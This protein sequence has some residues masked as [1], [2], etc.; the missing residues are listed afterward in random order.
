MGHE[1]LIWK[2]MR[3]SRRAGSFVTGALLFIC[4]Y[5]CMLYALQRSDRASLILGLTTGVIALR[6]IGFRL[7]GRE[8]GDGD[9]ISFDLPYKIIYITMIIGPLGLLLFVRYLYPSQINHRL[10]WILLIVASPYYTLVLISPV[11]VYT[12]YL[13]ILKYLSLAMVA[14][15][16]YYLWKGYRANEVGSYISLLGGL[17]FGISCVMDV[18]KASGWTWLPSNSLSFG[19]LVFIIAQSQ[20]VALQF[21]QAFRRAQYLTVSLRDEVEHQTRDTACILD[22]IRQGVY[23]VD[24]ENLAIGAVRSPYLNQI[25][26]HARDSQTLDDLLI[27]PMQVSNDRKSQLTSTIQAAIGSDLFNFEVNAKCLVEEADFKLEHG[28]SRHLVLDWAPMVDD[29]DQVDKILVCLRDLTEERQL[30]SQTRHHREQ[31][32]MIEELANITEVR[33]RRF[34]QRTRALIE[35]NVSLI[36]ENPRAF[37]RHVVDYLFINMHTIKGSA[38]TYM[39]ASISAL[40]HDLEQGYAALIKTERSWNADELIAELQDLAAV[41]Q[42]YE[43]LGKEKLHW[44][45]GDK[46]L[47]LSIA[48]LEGYLEKAERLSRA[49]RSVSREADS[50]LANLVQGFAA[51]AATPLATIIDDASKGL[52]SLARD[53]QKETPLIQLSNNDIFIRNAG[54][55]LLHEVLVH[56]LRNSIDHGI[57]VPGERVAAGKGVRGLIQLDIHINEEVLI[58]E[59]YDDGRGLNLDLIRQKAIDHQLIREEDQ[60]SVEDTAALIFHSG[61][62]TKQE[63]SQVSGRG[64]GMDAVRSNLQKEGGDIHMLLDPQ[65]RNTPLVSFKFQLI[66]PARFWCSSRSYEL[67]TLPQAV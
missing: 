53:L 6:T 16:C 38:R 41:L 19:L 35:Q 8:F 29:Q 66:I 43:T 2:E 7:L 64:V 32:Q 34:A 18:L 1:A 62:S 26:P 36:Q 20:I 13:G 30:Q 54:D 24:D 65:A 40:S 45:L 37:D 3:S 50:G 12:D 31:L 55:E 23:T 22:V 47:K 63:V 60:L 21:S 10:P 61:L 39:L 67:Q 17:A 42:R 59:F 27:Q 15:G 49:E 57:E 5:S 56:L 25:L 9:F 51:L 46:V 48:D 28:D 11:A 33:F 14:F 4:F 52:D 44:S 58:I